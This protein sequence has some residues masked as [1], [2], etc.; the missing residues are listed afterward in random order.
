MAE[1]SYLLNLRNQSLTPES[2]LFSFYDVNQERVCIGEHDFYSL[3]NNQKAFFSLNTEVVNLN[4]QLK[5]QELE[6]KKNAELK[7]QFLGM[8][9][10]DLR[11]PLT[12]ITLNA[13]FLLR[14]LKG[15]NLPE[16]E[17]RVESISQ[18]SKFM[19][20][21]IKNLLD[22]SKIESGKLE[23]NS[24]ETDTSKMIQIITDFNRP[25]ALNKNIEIVT[26]FEEHLPPIQLDPNLIEQVL[27]NLISNAIKFSMPETRVLVSVKKKENYLEFSVQDQG[28]GIKKEELSRL[29]IPFQ[30]TST[31]STADE[32]STGLGLSIVKKIIELHNGKVWVESELGVGSTFSFSLPL[33]EDV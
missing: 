17:K 28:L 12:G 6:L 19:A 1:H 30:V 7:N 32:K 16:L 2:Y 25:A 26:A 31:K 18:L 27:N 21:L 4:R 5:K 33:T 23:L 9:S 8:A 20:N 22:I 15:A 29:F 14:K 13:S 3:V 10:H 11:N 24:A